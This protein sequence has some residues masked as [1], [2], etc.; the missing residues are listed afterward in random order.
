MANMIVHGD[1]KIKTLTLYKLYGELEAQESKWMK[2]YMDLGGPLALV[3]H[4]PQHAR[5][6]P[7]CPHTGELSYQTSYDN[8]PQ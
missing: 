4:L 3:A 6:R 1:S 7:W 8:S 2:D 5:Q